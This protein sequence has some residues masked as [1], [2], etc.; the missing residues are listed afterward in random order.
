MQDFC[1]QGTFLVPNRDQERLPVQTGA[2]HAASDQTSGTL[3]GELRVFL[4]G[5]RAVVVGMMNQGARAQWRI[6]PGG[7]CMEYLDL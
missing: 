6:K 3:A 1:E 7:D 4:E 5:C 2:L